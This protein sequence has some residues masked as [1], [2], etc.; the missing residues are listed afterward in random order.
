MSCVKPTTP[1]WQVLQYCSKKEGQCFLWI[2]VDRSPF[3]HK[4]I[5]KTMIE[6]QA[7][8]KVIFWTVEND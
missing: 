3:L 5:I 8:T 1:L 4:A 6:N 2:S 7:F